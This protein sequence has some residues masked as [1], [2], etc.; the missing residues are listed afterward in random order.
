[1][2]LLASENLN[3]FYKRV[4]I[5]KLY[6]RYLRSEKEKFELSRNLLKKKNE[7]L[8]KLK[9]EKNSVIRVELSENRQIEKEVLEKK[10][11]LQRILKKKK[12]I[13]EEIKLKEK[14]ASALE[15]ELKK[16]IDD[17]K[18]KIQKSS[19]KES[20]TPSEKVISN[21]FE[22]NLGRL[23]WPTE[24]GIITGKYGEHQ[25]PDYNSV[26]IRNDGI[27]ITTN[28]GENARSIFN[29][30]VSR[31]FT[32]PGEKFTVIIKHGNYY[33][34]YHNLEGVKVK[35]GQKVSTKEI[36]GKVYTNENTKETVLLFQIWEETEKKDPE[37][38]L[39]HN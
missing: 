37:L 3:Q 11:A 34:L 17:E 19:S 26:T 14:T 31:V 6:A 9:S 1:M 7:E 32:L 16:L 10:K 24:H 27:Y 18:I 13:E 35:P 36:I 2:Y 38:W 20:L 5:L 21:D 23:P 30:T 39:V 8:Y 22:K 28:V 25:H 12:E 29:G 33:S 15:K 4:K